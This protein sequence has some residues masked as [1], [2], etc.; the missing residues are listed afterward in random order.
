MPNYT[1]EQIERVM[2]ARARDVKATAARRP[3]VHRGAEEDFIPEIDKA[4]EYDVTTDSLKRRADVPPNVTIDS[5]IDAARKTAPHRFRD[6][7]PV[8]SHPATAGKTFGGFAPDVKATDD[9]FATSPEEKM[10]IG[11]ELTRPK[12]W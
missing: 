12:G 2:K 8:D 9:F 4:F 3:D 5:I 11:N 7:A 1:P 6:I 10:R